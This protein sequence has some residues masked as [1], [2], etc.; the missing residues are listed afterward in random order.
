[1]NARPIWRIRAFSFI[2]II[3]SLRLFFIAALG[4]SNTEAYYYTWSRF[5]AL[6]YY[7]HPPLIAAMTWL[8]TELFGGGHVAIRAGTWLST[9]LF[10]ILVQ[11][12]AERIVGARAAFLA[13][14]FVS[15][16]PMFMFAGLLVNPEGPLAPCWI[17]ALLLLD[18]MTER[19]E[20]WRPI[21]LGAIIGLGFLAKYTAV[22]LVPIALA[23]LATSSRSRRWLRRPSLYLGGLVSLLIVSPVLVWNA[24]RGW[25]T[26][27]LHMSRRVGDAGSSLLADRIP[28]LTF[29]QAAL[30]HPLVWPLLLLSTLWMIRRARSEPSY[31]LLTL[32]SLPPLSFFYLVMSSVDD[33]ESHWTMLA[34]VP[35]IVVLAS[36][37]DERR[38][39]AATKAYLG[40]FL[41]S[42]AAIIALGLVHSRTDFLV[43][44][45]PHSVYEPE[46]DPVNNLGEWDTLTRALRESAARLGPAIAVASTH[47]VL[48][49]R[50][51]YELEDW[52]N[53]YC[54]TRE[55][56]AYEFVGRSI[57]PTN[58]VLMVDSEQYPY[59]SD[60]L[61][62]FDCQPAEIVERR[63][64]G[65]TVGRYRLHV[66]RNEVSDARDRI[67]VAP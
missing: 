21:A 16:L 28:H 66:C 43:R 40:A 67:V 7:D 31:R 18:E 13:V 12:F 37:L 63:R 51:M 17:A 34:H 56:T 22:L 65:R 42:A 3:A 41:V 55:P 35:Q 33:A 59:R 10:A 26:I 48:C 58:T 32:A 4:L 64:G 53:V 19:D 54:P 61:D 24:Q 36:W 20:R 9:A 49:G 6:S 57:P 52:P 5:P 15:L 14:V 45:L 60:A 1:M 38:H 62:R 44:H 46:G 27:A 8:T 50:I 2:A 23:F 29:L 39:L 25:P 30:F 11:R 47:N